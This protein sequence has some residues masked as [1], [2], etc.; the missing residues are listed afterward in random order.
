MLAAPLLLAAAL[1]AADTTAPAAAVGTEARLKK[2]QER[3]Q[4]LE[5]EIEALRGQEKS[6]LGD[7]ER[8]ELQV[9]LRTQELHE[10][11]LA[12]RHTREEM[13]AAQKRADDL[14]R[15]LAAARPAVIAR[16]RALYKLGEF[17]YA[18]MLLSIDRPVDVLRAYRFVSTL[19]REDRT[20]VAHF[21]RDLT[22]LGETR[23]EL[24]KKDQE[25][26]A[27]KAEAERRRKRLDSER[28]DKT[29]L[30]TTIV[31]KKEVHLAFAEELSQAE[32][33]LEEILSGSGGGE[34]EV[35]VPIA[36]LRG[37][38]PWPVD[39]KVRVGFGPRRNPRF[40][41]VTAHNGIEIEAAAES[42][43]HAVHEG[44]VAYAGHFLG[45]GLMVAIDHGHKHH[46]L[47][48][49]LADIAVALHDHVSAGQVLGTLAAEEPAS[50]YFELRF[51]GKPVD[52]DDWLGKPEK[53]PL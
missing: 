16:V 13:D 49:H 31:E 35:A 10:M 34:G 38:L 23:A 50:L 40:D 26:Q 2:V 5:R 53:R 37:S 15:S 43:V 32:G 20:R 30:L 14:E 18:R 25:M 22:A 36:A 6:L 21:R 52:P 12:L 9:R 19:A 27:Q 24:G 17:S 11:Q 33:K 3:R 8:L 7:V 41:T 28:K 46:T 42:P 1:A 29:A 45:Y 39:G 44:T 47:Y 4:A 51:Q 48:A